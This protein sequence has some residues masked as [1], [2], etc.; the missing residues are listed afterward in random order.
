MRLKSLCAGFYLI[1]FGLSTARADVP[2][3]VIVPSGTLIPRGTTASISF[4]H[5]EGTTVFFKLPSGMPTPKP[6]KTGIFDLNYIDVLTPKEGEPYF[7]FSG[8]QCE[9]CSDPKVLYSIR[10]SGGTPLTFVYPGRILEPKS[11]AVLSDYRT[12][13][14]RCLPNKGD[15][16][17]YYEQ[18]K[19]D[20]KRHLQSSVL[21]VEAGPNFLQETLVERNI[22]RI[23]NTLALVK[24]KQC[25]EISGINRLMS[26][27]PLDIHPHAEVDN[28]AGPEETDD[29]D[30]SSA[31]PT[32]APVN[33]A[34][35]KDVP[36]PP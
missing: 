27:K 11:R 13:I 1:I 32:P 4:D 15:M 20:R 10:A 28:G 2:S 22:P 29:K 33:P 8:K 17:I 18:E 6:F 5:V 25:R 26:S 23:K 3:N 34:D 35:A 12:F 9:N 31:T 36:L 30:T 24:R 19:L 21:V 14:G 7:I 16:L